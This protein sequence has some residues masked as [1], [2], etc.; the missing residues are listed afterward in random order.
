MRLINDEGKIHCGLL[1]GKSR[2]TLK[3]FLS[4]PIPELTAAALSVKMACLIRKELN[5]GNIAEKFWTDSQVV[6]AYIRS[7]KNRFKVF[8]AHRV[9]KIQEHSDVNQWKY[10]KGK[11]NPVD[12]TS[13]GLDPRK[14]KVVYWTCIPVA[15]RRTLAKL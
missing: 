3:K 13:R 14:E 5:S 8:V 2:V 15:K 7:T 10:V 12:D 1:V 4:I 9:Q 11:D 6:V